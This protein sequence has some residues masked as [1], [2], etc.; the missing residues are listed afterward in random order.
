MW[1]NPLCVIVVIPGLRISDARRLRL[2][3]AD[4]YLLRGSAEE[5]GGVDAAAGSCDGE[6]DVAVL[7]DFG[8]G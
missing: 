7:R 6:G 4:G 2:A 1:E 3:L 5:L 8:H